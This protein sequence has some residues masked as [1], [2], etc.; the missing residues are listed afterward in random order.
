MFKKIYSALV[1]SFFLSAASTAFS[2]DVAPVGSAD[3]QPSSMEAE[4]QTELLIKKSEE[5]ALLELKSE[6]NLAAPPPAANS[7]IVCCYVCGFNGSCRTARLNSKSCRS[8][9]GSVVSD[10]QCN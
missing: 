5:A 6:N 3:A 9:G 1:L 8:I 7:G 2:A 10:S 4:L